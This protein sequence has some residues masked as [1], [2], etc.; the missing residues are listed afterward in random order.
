MFKQFKFLIF[1][2]TLKFAY[3]TDDHQSKNVIIIVAD[4]LGFHDL[5]FR[6]SNEIPSY[7][8]DALA[9][10]G[11]ILDRFYTAPM[12][13]PSRAAL[14][15]GK[16]PHHLGMQNYVIVSDEPYGLPL[17]VKL[18]PEFFKDAGY[19]THLIGKWHLGFFKEEYTPFHRGFDHVFGYLGPYIDYWDYTLQMFNRNYS[20]GYDLR[21]NLTVDKTYDRVYATDM[22]T[23]ET[24]NAIE[25]HNQEKPLFLILNHLA[26][27]AGNVD[28]PLQAKEEDLKKFPYIENEERKTLAAMISSLDE[29]V[30]R[31]I[32][33][34]HRTGMLENSIIVFFSDNGGPTTFQH[35]TTA[36]NYPL[37]SQKESAWEGG[38]RTDAL[39][40]SPSLPS[41]VLRTQYFHISDLLPTLLTLAET[42]IKVKD[43]IDGIDLSR[44]IMNDMPPYRD[45]I[46]T[47]DD[48]SGYGSYIYSIFK[49]VNGSSSNGRADGWIGSNNNSDV[50]K[51]DYITGVLNSDVAQILKNYENPLIPEEILEIRENATVKC[52]GIISDC[53]LLRGPCLFDISRDPCEEKNLEPT[54][55][56][57]FDAMLKLYH[58]SLKKLVP[59]HKKPLDPQC[60]PANFNFTWKWWE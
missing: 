28:F 52:S 10:N 24:I 42:N 25:N 57:L 23:Q 21:R 11:I 34:L 60:D 27:H 58:S 16:Y 32:D 40:Y 43:K 15:T 22:F 50:N 39:I 48:V 53:D 37:R 49:L 5:S 13:T 4:D 20:R 1:L 47:V 9:Y 51:D 59:S 33:A 55:P 17:D 3:L 35:A 46:V 2:T 45:E 44:M 30:G 8:I 7:N 19:V 41:G 12:C 18:M 29:S 38:I 56:L 31:I 54:N 26:P 36:S 6:G 14:L